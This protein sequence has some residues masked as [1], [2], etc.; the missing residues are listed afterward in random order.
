MSVPHRKEKE[1][2]DKQISLPFEGVNYTYQQDN[3]NLTVFNINKLQSNM[4]YGR[5]KISAPKVTISHCW[6][7][8]K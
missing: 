5:V 4:D 2:I 1:Y 8:N 7:T 3:F 6:F